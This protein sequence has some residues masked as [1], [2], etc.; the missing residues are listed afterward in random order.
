MRI[1]NIRI[2]GKSTSI[3]TIHDKFVFIPDYHRVVSTAALKRWYKKTWFCI[4]AQV[5]R[6]SAVHCQMTRYSQRVPGYL[7][8]YSV[9]ANEISFDKK[10]Q[11]MRLCLSNQVWPGR[12]WFHSPLGDFNRL[13]KGLIGELSKIWHW[14]MFYFFRWH[15][16]GPENVNL[17]HC[18][19]GKAS[20]MQCPLHIKK[21]N[22]PSFHG[23]SCQLAPF[24]SLNTQSTVLTNNSVMVASVVNGEWR[25]Q[26]HQNLLN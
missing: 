10:N 25:W 2:W 20:R 23:A 12:K 7:T 8:R 21:V 15:Q 9:S 1:L 24:N 19:A 26:P 17:Y 11:P 16:P 18:C 3:D 14:N 6:L 13:F 4:I 5:Y 22:K